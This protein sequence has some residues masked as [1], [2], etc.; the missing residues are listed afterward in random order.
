[1][2]TPRD[3]SPYGSRASVVLSGR[4]LVARRLL[5]ELGGL[6]ALDHVAEGVFQELRE[7]DT[8]A[9]WHALDLRRDG[10]VG[11]DLNDHLALHDHFLTTTLI[12]WS[13]WFS[14]SATVKPCFLASAVTLWSA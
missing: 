3:R 5:V 2:P 8:L 11:S 1:D 4:D 14:T 6:L 7:L 13:A 10:A 12:V 9:A